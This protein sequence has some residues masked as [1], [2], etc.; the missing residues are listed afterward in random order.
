M[1][2]CRIPGCKNFTLTSELCRK[3]ELE[4]TQNRVHGRKE[5]GMKVKVVS[6]FQVKDK[7]GN[8]RR[9][10]VIELEP[11]AAE[12]ALT[13]GWVEKVKAEPQAASDKPTAR[14]AT[15]KTA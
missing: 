10:G 5:S 1:G 4:E 2:W 14:K 8:I 3:H 11:A 12:R 6:G 7:E 13:N 15:R 9:Q